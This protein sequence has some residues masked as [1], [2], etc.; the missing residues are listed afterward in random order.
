MNVKILCDT[1]CRKTGETI[2][3][4]EVLLDATIIDG[5]YSGEWYGTTVEVY[6]DDAAV[7]LSNG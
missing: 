7:M 4:G 1:V 6:A 3:A 5:G 2:Q